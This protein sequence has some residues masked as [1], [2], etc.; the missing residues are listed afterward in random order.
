MSGIEG[1][2][3][4]FY[5]LWGFNGENIMREKFLTLCAVAFLSTTFVG[6]NQGET[7]GHLLACKC[8]EKPKQEKPKEEVK[9]ACKCKHK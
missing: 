5:S 3:S 9:L 6:A 1:D 8:Q 7:N 2:E 4:S